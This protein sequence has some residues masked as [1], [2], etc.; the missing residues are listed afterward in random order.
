MPV[1][2]KHL[3][4]PAA[5]HLPGSQEGGPGAHGTDKVDG[6]VPPTVVGQRQP[7]LCVLQPADIVGFPQAG[8]HLP[9]HLQALPDVP[10]KDG[11]E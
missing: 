10:V 1:S 5:Q 8:I 11:E 2:R 6:Q 7:G 9:P 4:H 3:R